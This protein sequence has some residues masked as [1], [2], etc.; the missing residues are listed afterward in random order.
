M[1]STAEKPTLSSMAGFTFHIDG[2]DGCFE[3]WE[4]WRFIQHHVDGTKKPPQFSIID[5]DTIIELSW[6]S[7]PSETEYEKSLK[8]L[9][10]TALVISENKAS[11]WDDIQSIMIAY[12]RLKTDS[13]TLL[14]SSSEMYP[15]LERYRLPELDEKDVTVIMEAMRRALN[16]ALEKIPS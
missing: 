1:G 2:Q 7:D 15:S 12:R 10:D 13:D 3:I 5:D 16:N 9:R 8:L 6:L 4:D 11:W 14:K